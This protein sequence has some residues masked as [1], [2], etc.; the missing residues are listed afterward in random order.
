MMAPLT[1]TKDSKKGKL[2]EE[3][4]N[5]LLQISPNFLQLVRLHSGLLLQSCVPEIF[6]TNI[7]YRIRY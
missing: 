1:R 2:S 4:S 3:I 6:I 7:R 5:H